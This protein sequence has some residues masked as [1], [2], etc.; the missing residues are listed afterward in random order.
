MNKKWGMALWS[1]TH[2]LHRHTLFYPSRLWYNTFELP[3]R[4][5]RH[6]QLPQHHVARVPIPSSPRC[7]YTGV[8]AL[9]NNF[10]LPSFSTST[11]PPPS[12]ED[13]CVSKANYARDLHTH[14]HTLNFKCINTLPAFSGVIHS[15]RPTVPCRASVPYKDRP[16]QSPRSQQTLSTRKHDH[17]T[18]FC[19]LTTH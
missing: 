3:R 15:P 14:T 13:I 18:N 16:L 4:T 6:E 11:S 19:R 8:T 17:N 9:S 12:P 7:H 2:L 10:P 1:H 5:S